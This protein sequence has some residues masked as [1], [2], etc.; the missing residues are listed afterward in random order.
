MAQV[1]ASSALNSTWY[2][3]L[4]F[5]VVA[6]VLLVTLAVMGVLLAN[7]HRLTTNALEVQTQA[8]L[9]S[10]S[11]L[12]NAALAGRVFQRDH[13][14]LRSITAELVQTP[15]ADILYIE[16]AT[17]RG[18]V[19]ARAGA[20]ADAAQ[21]SSSVLTAL[22]Q[23]LIYHVRKPLS[24]GADVEVGVVRFG[25]S[26]AGLVGLR[27]NM[28]RQSLLIV[29]VTLPLAFVLLAWGGYR[30]AGRVDRQLKEMREGEERYRT[31]FNAPDDA[32]FVHEADSGRIVDV[33]RAMLV[34]YGFDYQS[35][36][37]LGVGEIS[38]NVPPYTRAEAEKLLNAARQQGSQRF[39][40]LCR[41]RDGEL[42][43]GEISLRLDRIGDRDFIIGVNRNIND[44]K[45]AEQALEEEKEWLATTLQSIG[46]GVITTDRQGRVLMLNKLAA[47]LTGWSAA[48]AAGR[49]LPEVFA[50]INERTG[51]PAKNPVE[52]VLAEGKIVTLENHTVLIAR[53]GSRKPIADSG[54]PIRNREGEIIGVVLVFRDMT[55]QERTERELLKIK[56]L[57]SVGVLAAG[58][59][60]D[61]N[62]LLTAILGN[63]DLARY[64]AKEQP[65][66]VN[67]LQEAKKAG[68][69]A[70]GLTQQLLTFAR[71]GDPVRQVASLE[72][73]IRDSSRFVLR[74]SKVTCDYDIP[75]DLW[76]VEI[77]QGQ[78]S[79][80]IQNIV[81]NARQAMAEGGRITITGR[82]RPADAADQARGKGDEVAITIS[83]DGPGVEPA[84]LEKIFDPYFTTKKEGSGL[85]L[86]ICHSI[87]DKHDG[88]ITVDSRPAAGTTFT[89]TLPASRQ[90]AAEVREKAPITV[91]RRA[92]ILVMDDE[93]MVR[94]VMASSLTAL[95]HEVVTV[96]DGAEALKVYREAMGLS[97]PFDLVIMDLTVPGGMGG[98][99]AVGKLRQL[100]PAARVV[101]ASGYADDR[102]M[103]HH[104]DYGFAA[105]LSKPVLLEELDRVVQTLL[106]PGEN[107]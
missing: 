95:G 15:D 54:A 90:S 70:R 96:A 36:L 31:I 5:R 62:N 11:P 84:V 26:L 8:R 34:M 92:K 24:L 52:K 76:L 103:A 44:R 40:W 12:L 16:V 89:I 67:L 56:K 100:D 30:L 69:R 83:D 3:S 75:P 78:I 37:Q 60:H 104:R 50:I 20:M 61:F 102:I 51:E 87:V 47:E 91:R 97:A 64:L 23:G 6:A 32:I 38:A 1:Q 13:S 46:D 28:I 82:N 7:G 88:K 57:E 43:W 53:N 73:V 81:L 93:T 35:A 49:P 77:D 59:A 41:R 107:L 18:E 101:V 85:G 48:E 19:I 106:E 14:E 79:Q 10:L 99:E 33:N 94:Q 74:G 55:E 25:L 72:A 66:I 39:E 68:L 65:P 45:L 98:Q 29:A 27:D 71:G 9:D 22:E 63:V 17:T 4:Q 42:F 86:T 80:V 105:R 58:I 2:R 21:P